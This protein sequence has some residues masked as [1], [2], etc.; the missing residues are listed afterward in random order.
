MT[1]GTAFFPTP[2]SSPTFSAWRPDRSLS[3]W[4]G[5]HTISPLALFIPPVNSAMSSLALTTVNLGTLTGTVLPSLA[6]PLPTIAAS[7][8]MS[9]PPPPPASNIRT[10]FTFAHFLLPFFQFAKSDLPP[11]LPTDPSSARS[12]PTLDGT[13]LIGRAFNDP[14]LGLCR[15]TEVGP[16][17]R[18]APGEGNLDPTGPQ[19]QALQ[20]G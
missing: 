5:L 7:E 19:L 15:L 1:S 13:D 6:L 12:F 9:S 16:P 4:S 10:T 2:K 18:L 17:H 3:A 8:L 11:P 20:V 14:D